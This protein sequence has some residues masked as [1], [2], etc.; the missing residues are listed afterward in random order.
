MI[1]KAEDLDRLIKQARVEAEDIIRKY[2]DQKKIKKVKYFNGVNWHILS[3]PSTQYYRVCIDDEF[4]F[5]AAHL[6]ELDFLITS[7][8][9]KILKEAIEEGKKEVDDK[10]KLAEDIVEKAKQCYLYEDD[11]ID[12][13]EHVQNSCFGY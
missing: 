9:S 4:H 8:G 6:T 1:N 5:L 2:L 13:I 7:E 11:N 10:I 3:I 12:V